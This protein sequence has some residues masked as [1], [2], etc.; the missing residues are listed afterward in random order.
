MIGD[1]LSPGFR[2][3]SALSGAD[4]SV[5]TSVRAREALLSIEKLSGLQQSW[6][7]CTP[8]EHRA[9]AALLRLYAERG[10]APDIEDLAKRLGSDAGALRP[11]LE[12]LK[13]RDVIVLD[14]EGR[15]V[16][17]YPFR[18]RETGHRVTLDGRTLNAMCAIDALGVGAMYGCDVQIQ[19]TCRFC[20]ASIE[21]ATAD[22]GRSVATLRPASAIVWS[23]MRYQDGCAADSLCTL[24]AFFCRDAH[25]ESWRAAHASAARGFELSIEE[26]LQAGRAIFGP[27]L[28]QKSE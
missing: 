4:W 28:R 3:D 20:R 17:A 13:R 11:I 19:S 6:Y 1:T 8:E 12:S 15:I 9:R 2:E 24:I 26:A 16:G 7:G 22:E 23:G 25:L 21:I 18:D 10:R 27:V 5:V 14:A